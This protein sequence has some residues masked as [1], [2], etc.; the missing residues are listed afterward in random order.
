MKNDMFYVPQDKNSF[1]ISEEP[2]DQSTMFVFEGRVS[3][4]NATEIETRLDTAIDS[5]RKYIVLDMNGVEYLSS[6]GIRVLLKAYKRASDL[7]GGV[8]IVNPSENVKNILCLSALDVL[9]LS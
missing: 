7:G 8:K 6:T 2:S 1:I 5:G 9:L 4:Q 3:A